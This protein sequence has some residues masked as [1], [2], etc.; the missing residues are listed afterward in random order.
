MDVHGLPNRVRYERLESYLK[1]KY[2][3]L[4]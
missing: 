2:D 4:N 1:Q 3:F